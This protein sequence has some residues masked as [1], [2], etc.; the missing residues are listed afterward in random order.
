[1][2]HPD[3][4]VE[5]IRRHSARSRESL[6]VAD[7]LRSLLPQVLRSLKR[8]YQSRGGDAERHALNDAVYLDRIQE[9]LDV[10]AEGLEAKIQSETHRMMLQAMHTL[11]AFRRAAELRQQ[12]LAESGKPSRP[13][14]S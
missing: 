5:L 3:H 4:L 12:R 8:G 10:Y 11:N 14:V 6:Q 2:M 7:R 1:M 9:Y 13:S